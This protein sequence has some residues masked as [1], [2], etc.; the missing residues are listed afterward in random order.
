MKLR[1]LSTLALA[2]IAWCA[3]LPFL[4]STSENPVLDTLSH[5]SFPAHSLRLTSP[6]SSLC[7]KTGAKSWAGYLDVNLDKI[8]LPSNTSDGS[9]YDLHPKG[10]TEHIYFWAFESRNDPINDPVVLWINGGPGCSSFTGLLME[11]GP[12]SIEKDGKSTKLNP[13]SWNSNATVIFLDQPVGVGFSYSS[14]THPHKRDKKEKVPTRS[15]DTPSAARDT[16]AFLHLLG[17]HYTSSKKEEKMPAL[18]LAGESYA[19][20]YL[21]LIAE[22]VLQ[23][24]QE[25]ER[26]PERGIKPLRLESIMVG[27]GFVSPS[28]QFRAYADYICKNTH[29]WGQFVSDKECEEMYRDMP[30]CIALID[31][32]NLAG[33]HGKYDIMACEMAGEYCE[34]KLGEAYGKTGRSPYDF[35]KKGDYI[36]E[37]WIDTFLNNAK[38]QRQ[39]GI[40]VG[41]DTF[42]DGHNG[43]F[44]GC[45]N[46]VFNAF[47]KTGDVARS[48][49]W[50]V[51]SL[52][53]KD[54]RVLIYEGTKDWICNYLG[55]E[56]W[57]FDLKGWSGNEDFKALPKTNW[58]HPQT[59]DVVGRYRKL[60]DKM[61][62]V[63]IDRAGHFVPHDQ[64]E[65]SLRMVNAW[66][67][68][69]EL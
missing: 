40:D 63:E 69:G 52:L 64:G 42:G 45:S 25:A 8:S 53:N 13:F 18:H 9:H 49:K 12:C 23:D 15:F 29:G 33:P 57:T 20:R 22:Q 60:D 27:N 2:P 36:E 62:Y 47:G 30:T 17:L 14:W 44:I 7:E 28:H 26:H 37:E 19:G 38:V 61:M 43:R 5:P 4:T 54:V 67:H 21:P 31:K 68:G 48:S 46:K 3:Q 50:A 55:S 24:N 59:G 51:E 41:R 35:E 10:V 32:C 1:L 11:L 56:A 58:K 16:S 39:L 6:P 34:E 66:L 65:N